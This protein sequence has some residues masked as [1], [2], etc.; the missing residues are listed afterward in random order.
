M[1]GRKGHMGTQRGTSCCCESQCCKCKKKK[2]K[3]WMQIIRAPVC[4]SHKACHTHTLTHTH[5]HTLSL[6]LLLTHTLSLFTSR[7]LEIVP[8]A[9]WYSKPCVCVCVCVCVWF[10]A[11][12]MIYIALNIILSIILL[13]C[14]VTSLV[15]SLSSFFFKKKKLR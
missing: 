7:R 8:R 1:G 14:S 9:Q 11:H 4:V 13:S 6:S 5:T 12:E 2:E 10:A 15:I 3:K